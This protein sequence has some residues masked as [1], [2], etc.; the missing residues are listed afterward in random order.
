MEMIELID[1]RIWYVALILIV[2]VGIFATVS[3]RGLQV[4][5]LREMVRVTFFKNRKSDEGKL[6]SFHVF[7]M[8]MGSRIGVGNITGPILAMMAGGP[9]A[10][11]WMWIFAGLGMATSFLETTIGQIYKTPNENGGFRGGPAY[12]LFHGL[13]M[14]RLGMVAAFV[15]ILMYLVGFVSG[16]VISMSEAVQGAFDYEWTHLVFAII[17]TFVICFFTEVFQGRNIHPAQYLLVGLALCLFYTLLLAT[18]EHTGFALAYAL[19]SVM[20][21]G[22][23]TF[24]LSGVLRIRRTALVIG[25]LLACLYAY[26]FLLIRMET[27]ALLAG[28]LGLF[29]ILAV[30]MYFSQKIKWQ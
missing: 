4:T 22:L 14:K 5:S 19:A 27:Y 2:V 13:G 29:A 1:D 20:T 7:C 9:G 17:L 25:G 24:Y 11:L 21:V 15:M 28:S 6:S 26:V 10:I 23:I 16:E 12:T 3:L 18:A 8:S 30:V